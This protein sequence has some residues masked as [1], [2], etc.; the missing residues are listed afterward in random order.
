MAQDNGSS[1]LTNDQVKKKNSGKKK[2]FNR[3]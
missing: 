3:F 1:Y 2:G